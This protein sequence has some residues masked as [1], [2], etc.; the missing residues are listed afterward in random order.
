MIK[1]KHILPQLRTH[2]QNQEVEYA[3]QTRSQMESKARKLNTAC[4]SWL[5]VAVVNTD[6]E[7][8]GDERLYFSL[9]F[10]VH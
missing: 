5:T 6:Q 7:Q 9:H 10:T 4:S 1:H 8:L 3:K 2:E